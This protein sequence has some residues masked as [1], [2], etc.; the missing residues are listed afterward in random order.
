MQSSFRN[1]PGTK[2]LEIAI[3]IET[4]NFSELQLL[5]TYKNY[6]TF[7]I[8]QN[9]NMIRWSGTQL[10]IQVTGLSRCA[11]IAVLPTSTEFANLSVRSCYDMYVHTRLFCFSQ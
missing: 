7:S 9:D 6:F 5:F 10:D 4:T 8:H 1:S 11:S 3:A 2:F